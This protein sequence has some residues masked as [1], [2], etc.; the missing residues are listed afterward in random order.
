MQAVLKEEAVEKP[1]RYFSPHVPPP[2]AAAVDGYRHGSG[3]I[4]SSSCGG[5]CMCS[6]LDAAELLLFG[7][8]FRRCGHCT[9]I[10]QAPS[11]AAAAP[12]VA[13][14]SDVKSTDK[15]KDLSTCYSP[16]ACLRSV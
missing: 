12:A 3:C 6:P 8:S 2:V 9:F 15:V 10:L 14:P 5:S 4:C 13:R 7:L 16:C 11:P 1:V